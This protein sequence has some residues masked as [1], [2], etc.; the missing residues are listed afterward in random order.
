MN[1]KVLA[2]GLALAAPAF[3]N[4]Q[5][6]VNVLTARGQELH[7]EYF[8]PSLSVIYF[9]DKD[10]DIDDAEKQ[11]V[12]SQFDINELPKNVYQLD[13]ANADIQAKIKSLKLGNQVMKVWYPEFKDGA[14]TTEVI[15]KRGEYSATDNDI[16]QGKASSRGTDF[17]KLGESLIDRS[18]IIV[19]TFAYSKD[20][21]GGIRRDKKGKA[22]IKS[23]SYLYKLDFNKEV[24]TAFYEKHFT[25]PNGVELANFPIQYIMEGNYD[26]FKKKVSDFKVQAT[27]MGIAP[28]VAKVGLKEGV[29]IDDRYDVMELVEKDGQ[30]VSKR[31]AVVR[32]RSKIADNSDVATG[33]T[34][35]LTQFYKFIGLNVK[36]GMT[37]VEHHELGFS[38]SPF[39]QTNQFGVMIDYRTKRFTGLA[40]YT[41]FDIPFGKK[42]IIDE[43]DNISTKTGLLSIGYKD[44]SKTSIE[45]ELENT[46]H[47]Y[48]GGIGFIQEFNFARNFSASFGVGGGWVFHSGDLGTENS[49][50]SKLKT[51]YGEALGRFGLMLSPN[52]QLFAQAS[53]TYHLSAGEIDF[54]KEL[55][56]NSDYLSPL[57]IG[58]GAKVSF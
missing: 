42:I 34:T 35:D 3:M 6:E 40:V 32:V 23:K 38:V 20:E 39:V 53:Y 24:S 9:I 2:L 27:V 17:S 46:V 7:R 19:K 25:H 14:Y 5:E 47:F 41:K 36:E 13:L 58:V 43:Q 1:L 51:Y 15:E 16:I 48:R 22:I 54:A 50:E 44:S 52:F 12:S 56:N 55:F 31:R 30:Q 18:Y 21:N 49:K 11:F 10:F 29:K 8:R 4:A 28:I 26:D 45:N 57:G 33:D 37:L